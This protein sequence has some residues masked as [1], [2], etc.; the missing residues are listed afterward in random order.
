[1]LLLVFFAALRRPGGPWRRRPNPFA[2]ARRSAPTTTARAPPA[3]PPPAPP[4]PDGLDTVK[5]RRAPG[6]PSRSA[7]THRAAAP[8][9]RPPPAPSCTRGR[10]PKPRPAFRTRIQTSPTTR[11]RPPRPWRRLRS[12]WA[13]PSFVLQAGSRTGTAWQTR[14]KAATE[15]ATTAPD[16]PPALTDPALLARRPA[17][18]QTASPRAWATCTSVAEVHGGGR[19]NRRAARSD[20]TVRDCLSPP[21]SLGSRSP[22]APAPGDALARRADTRSE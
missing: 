8:R 11:P 17:S 4:D 19:S 20:R 2:P 18:S 15:I 7:A 13:S 6:A 1:M 14:S 22:R 12:R 5:V 9:P 21:Q 3:C 16:A 10:D